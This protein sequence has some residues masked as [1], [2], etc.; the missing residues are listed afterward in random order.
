MT[1]A[2]DITNS[3][4]PCRRLLLVPPMIA[5]ALAPAYMHAGTVHAADAIAKIRMSIDEDA[6]ILQLAAQLGYL[7]QEK[8]EIVPVDVGNIARHDYLM[9]EPL[10][11]GEIDAAFQWFHHALFGARH[12]FPIQAVMMFN[13]A[14]GMTIM[15]ANRAKEKIRSAADFRGVRVAEG[16]GYA[17]KSVITNFL[18]RKAGLAADSYTPVMTAVEGRQDGVLKALAEGQVEVITFRE[19]MTSAVQASGLVTTLYDLNSRETTA[20]IFGTAYP[21]QSLLMAPAYLGAHPQIAQRLVNAMTRTMR[22]INRHS[23]EQIAAALPPA[24]FEKKDRQAEIAHMKKMLPTY[25]KSEYA[26]PPAAARLVLE[27]V[28]A[29]RFDESEEGQWRR[30]AAVRNIDAKTL[31]DNRFVMK[32]MAMIK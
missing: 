8:I 19:P 13:D 17:T 20:K 14:P 25:A 9:Q 2:R 18:V 26:I 7:K 10:V 30:G 22:F 28:S 5:L 31:Y 21:A 32:A 3:S 16:A 6:M 29:S 23:A 12:G 1:H 24:Y 15:V 11:K 4:R 27:M